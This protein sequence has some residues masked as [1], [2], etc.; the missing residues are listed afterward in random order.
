[1]VEGTEEPVVE[2]AE[3]PVVER[4]MFQRVGMIHRRGLWGGARE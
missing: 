1:M 4:Q 2:G 3:E